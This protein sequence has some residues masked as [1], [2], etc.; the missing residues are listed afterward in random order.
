M[1]SLPCYPCQFCS[2]VHYQWKRFLEDVDDVLPLA[3]KEPV[4]CVQQV[5][6]DR[7]DPASNK[8]PEQYNSNPDASSNPK[9]DGDNSASNPGPN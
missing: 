5:K 7:G 1:E 2:R 4:K 6:L 8:D 9:L 3:I